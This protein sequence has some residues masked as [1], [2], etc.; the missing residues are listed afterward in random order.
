MADHLFLSQPG[1][2]TGIPPGQWPHSALRTY[3]RAG[4]LLRAGLVLL[5]VLLFTPCWPV[6]A[7]AGDG[8]TILRLLQQ[9]PDDSLH[10][11]SAPRGQN[12]FRIRP[13]VLEAMRRQNQEKLLLPVLGKEMLFTAVLQRR[14]RNKTLTWIGRSRDGSTSLL[15]MGRDHFFARVVRGSKVTVFRPDGEEMVAGILDPAMATALEDDMVFPA[16]SLPSAAAFPDPRT[17]EQP[18]TAGKTAAM[19]R[20]IDVMVLYTPGMAAVYPGDAIVTRIQYLVDL[21]NQSLVNSSIHVRFRLVHTAE[22]NYAD[23]GSMDAALQ[24]LTQGEG[25]FRDVEELRDLY[26]ADQVT[27]LRRYVDDG[28]G[29]A[30]IMQ[31]SD[32]RHAYAVVH[33][34]RRSDGYYCDDLT[35]IH[36]VGHNLGCSHDRAHAGSPGMYDYSYGYRFPAQGSWYRTIM[37]YDC[38]GGC[39][40]ISY[41]SNPAVLYQGVPTGIADGSPDAADNGDTINRTSYL[42]RDYRPAADPELVASQ[43]SLGIPGPAT[44]VGTLAYT[45][46]ALYIENHGRGYLEIG[47]AGGSLQPPFFLDRDSCSNQEIAP[48][49]LNPSAPEHCIIRL[50][51]E[52]KAP[53]VYSGKLEIP[54]NDPGTPL[55][56]LTVTGTAQSTPPWIAATPASL[57]FGRVTA[58]SAALDL[59]LANKGKE[60]LEIGVISRSGRSSSPFSVLVDNCSG[61]TLAADR[62]C[63]MRIGFAPADNAVYRERVLVPSNDPLHDPLLIPLKGGQFPWNLFLPAM[64]H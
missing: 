44:E 4:R 24:A 36:E 45:D 54:S 16:A 34:G 14:N 25:V 30:W 3:R 6:P 40:Q 50:R 33:D 58:G 5:A 38:A 23:S 27:L 12:R 17:A 31:Y 43:T 10:L 19:D 49:W 15:T 62:T 41:F 60:N 51:F 26:G 35:Y 13:G 63:T 47:Q 7:F 53:G 2:G 52:P 28:C 56:T 48:S 37:S 18:A 32:A 8:R 64:R 29:L 22:K 21:A 46:P 20:L 59:V 61:Q 55:L 57:S 9:T 1:P 39:T 42:V 11:R